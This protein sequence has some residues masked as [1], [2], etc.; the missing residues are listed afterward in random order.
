MGA[1]QAADTVNLSAARRG[2]MMDSGAIRKRWPLGR[3]VASFRPGAASRLTPCRVK[4]R[5]VVVCFSSARMF[6]TSGPSFRPQQIRK[7]IS[8]AIFQPL[9]VL[10]F[11]ALE[12]RP[13]AGVP[14]G[15]SM[16]G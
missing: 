8:M 5:P 9:D 7:K 16:E 1:F 14:E 11:I 3:L 15:Y 4:K 12:A 2:V 6:I 13:V 10:D